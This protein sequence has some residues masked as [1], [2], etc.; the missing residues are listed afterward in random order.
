MGHYNHSLSVDATIMVSKNCPI[1]DEH[2]V[3]IFVTL[4]VTKATVWSAENTLNFS[5][6]YFYFKNGTVN[7]FL[8][9]NFDK[10]DKTQLPAKYQKILYMGFRA[11]LNFRK[12]ISGKFIPANE[13]FIWLF[14]VVVFIYLA[15]CSFKVLSIIMQNLV[16]FFQ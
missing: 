9:S 15:R 7:F 8:L 5:F 12:F 11:T 10:Q 6:K 1:I 16:L 3:I 4:Y 14:S 13:P 2:V